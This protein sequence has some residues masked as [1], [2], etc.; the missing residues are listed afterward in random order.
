MGLF[1]EV[2]AYFRMSRGDV[3]EMWGNRKWVRTRG[4]IWS[5]VVHDE[6]EGWHVVIK[7]SSNL[8]TYSHTAWVHSHATDECV[9]FH[10]VGLSPSASSPITSL[11]Q[12]DR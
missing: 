4:S 10:G 3:F 11:S 12:Q 2:A 7:T 1:L 9:N 8:L 5:R 6:L